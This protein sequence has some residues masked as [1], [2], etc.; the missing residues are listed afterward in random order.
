MRKATAKRNREEGGPALDP[1]IRLVPVLLRAL[2]GWT[3]SELARR[4]GIHPSALSKHE[5]GE[6]PLSREQ[7]DQLAAAAGVPLSFAELVLASAAVLIDAADRP[8]GG[9]FAADLACRIA[10]LLA[11][12]FAALEAR[13]A[14]PAVEP[15]PFDPLGVALAAEQWRRLAKRTPAQRALIIEHGREYQT[16]ALLVRLCDESE[17]AE[18]GSAADVLELAE[19]ALKIAALAQG[20]EGRRARR[21]GYARAFVANARRVAGLFPAADAALVQAHLLFSQGG[22]EDSGLLDPARIFDREALLRRSQGQP[23]QA[24]ALHAQALATCRPEHRVRLLINQSS[25][26]EQ[27]GDFAPAIDALLEA[28]PAIEIGEAGESLAWITR[29]NLAKMLLEAGRIDDASAMLHSLRREGEALG[30]APDLLRLRRVEARVAAALGQTAEALAELDAVRREFAAIPLPADAAITGLLEAE[31]L[32][33][34]DRT[35]KARTLVRS[36]RPIFDSL[37][38]KRETLASYRLFVAAI[39]R[40]AATTTQVR[41][42]AKAIERAGIRTDGAAAD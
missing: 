33:R 20:S 23:A 1:R 18:S 9:D 35:G 25:S 19:L 13:P 6:V 29:L 28:L 14:P 22:E 26:F 39:E 37:G 8:A 3:Q 34:D 36:L 5:L 24:L 40:E 17:A 16:E 31:I 10:A 41:E 32:V 27:A 4:A 21:E 2:H 42:L 11:P 38:L 15:D 30:T 7:L 12:V